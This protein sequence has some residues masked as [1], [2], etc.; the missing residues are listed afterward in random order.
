MHGGI[1][2]ALDPSSIF[3]AVI[4]CIALAAMLH[5]RGVAAMQTGTTPK[6]RNNFLDFGIKSERVVTR[7]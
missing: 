3:D 7:R 4:G 2:L 1:Y 5:R 6:M